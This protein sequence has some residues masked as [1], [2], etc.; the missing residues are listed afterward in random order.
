MPN[1]HSSNGAVH[2]NEKSAHNDF[3]FVMKYGIFFPPN[4][5]GNK[6]KL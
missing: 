4:D 5:N 6:N 3:D 1:P 2:S